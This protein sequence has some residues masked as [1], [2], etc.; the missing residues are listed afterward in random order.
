MIFYLFFA[1]AFYINK[2]KEGII[3]WITAIIFFNIMVPNQIYILEFLT[4]EIIIEFFL[5][6]ACAAYFPLVGRRYLW[7]CLLLSALCFGAFL[8]SGA[9]S[10]LR[11]LCGVGFA[12]LVV[13]LVRFEL[14]GKIVIATWLVFLGNASY[15]IYLI[16]NPLIS[17]T[18]RIAA[19]TTWMDS[20]VPAMLFSLASSVLLGCIY[21]LAF[22]RPVLAASRNF[23]SWPRPRPT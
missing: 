10:D 19:H 1:I 7:V 14:E 11:L 12:F 3:I 18:S 9:T 21:H 17:V 20:W 4:R 6:V 5:G 23:V 16:H 22:E 15:S 13:P 8:A 2:L